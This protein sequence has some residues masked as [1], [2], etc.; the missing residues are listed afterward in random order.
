MTSSRP[1]LVRA[2]YDWITDNNLTPYLL[3]KADAPG[4][5]APQQYAQNGKLILNISPGAIQ[6]LSLG[7]EA[8]EFSARFS[9][10]AMNVVVPIDAV[11]AVY[12]KEN[13]K[14][15]IFDQE[16]IDDEPPPQAKKPTA[17]PNLRIVK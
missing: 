7:N 15:M 11:L 2:I 14:G 1:Y 5:L 6:G 10:V 3:I 16:D 9:G 13:G 8:I 17:K 12:A 4:L